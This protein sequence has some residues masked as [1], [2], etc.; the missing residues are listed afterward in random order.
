MQLNLDDLVW[1]GRNQ[2]VLAPNGMVATSQPLAALAGSEILR[3]GGNAV[4][5]A[6]AMGAAAMRRARPEW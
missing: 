4:D 6:I 1:P 2:P 5:A 3:D